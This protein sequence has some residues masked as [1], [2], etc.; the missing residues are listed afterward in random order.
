VLSRAHEA[1]LAS[2]MPRR[3]ILYLTMKVRNMQCEALRTQAFFDPSHRVF[4][5]IAA[6]HGFVRWFSKLREALRGIV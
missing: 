6:D 5:T 3:F 1:T 4:E 2:R